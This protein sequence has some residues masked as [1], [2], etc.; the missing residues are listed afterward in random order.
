MLKLFL[1]IVKP[2]DLIVHCNDEITNESSTFVSFCGL[3]SAE[4]WSP[5]HFSLLVSII[6]NSRAVKYRK[7]FHGLLINS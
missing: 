4:F 2:L 6:P 3:L 1:A 5:T 7:Y